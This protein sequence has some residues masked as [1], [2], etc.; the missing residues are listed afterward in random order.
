MSTVDELTQRIGSLGEE[1]LLLLFRRS[2]TAIEVLKALPYV[3][4]DYS[5]KDHLQKDC[6]EGTDAYI[7]QGLIAKDGSRCTGLLTG[8]A[9]TREEVLAVIGLM[10]KRKTLDG[11]LI[12]TSYGDFGEKTMSADKVRPSKHSQ[13]APGTFDFG[14]LLSSMHLL[15]NGKVIPEVSFWHCFH[16]DREA[17][18][19]ARLVRRIDKSLWT[20]ILEEP[21]FFAAHRN[22]S[23][24][25][26]KE[27]L[28][29]DP[30]LRE[31]LN[32][33]GYEDLVAL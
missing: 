2:E 19:A 3:T 33:L 30:H 15:P 28:K 9:L 21:E 11:T 12:V 8:G 5:Q 27:A 31:L 22:Y 25:C 7:L 4:V 10:K 1:F 32:Q 13:Y 18:K 26:W 23:A 24:M 6:R 16:P 20:I 14:L 17:R 29:K